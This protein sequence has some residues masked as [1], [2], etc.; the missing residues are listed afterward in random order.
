MPLVD[1]LDHEHLELP[2]QDENRHHREHGERD[3]AGVTGAAIDGEQLGQIARGRGA[4]EQ[5][6]EP[7]IQPEGDEHSYRQERQQ[8]DHQLEGDGRYHALVVLA[9]IDVPRAEQ[10]GEGR[11]DEGHIER[12]VLQD[13]SGPDC[14]GITMSG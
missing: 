1:V 13:G 5:V 14:A 10:D 2:R 4:R 12:R 11:H 9:R 8:L 3:P 6:A 7:L